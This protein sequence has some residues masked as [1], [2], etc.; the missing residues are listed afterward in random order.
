MTRRRRWEKNW[1]DIKYCS[2]RCRRAGV[3]AT[4]QALEAAI[5]GL[6]AA[7]T[8]GASICPSEAARAVGGD[9]WRGLLERA[10]AA[11]RRLTARGRVEITQGGR[12]VDASTAR[13]PIRVRAIRR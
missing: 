9:D 10:R 5:L 12:P 4:D 1:A 13:G 6:L 11:A 8:A 3:D 2:A 7:R